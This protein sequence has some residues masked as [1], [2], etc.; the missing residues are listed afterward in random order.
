MGLEVTQTTMMH[1]ATQTAVLL[2]RCMIREVTYVLTSL[3]PK[4][5][6]INHILGS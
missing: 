1:A 2:R 6:N 5:V 4:M 3:I